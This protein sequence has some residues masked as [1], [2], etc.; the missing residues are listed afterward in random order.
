[1]N[2]DRLP[3]VTTLL[4][5]AL[6]AAACNS[7]AQDPQASPAVVATDA[8]AISAPVGAATAA[9]PAATSAPAAP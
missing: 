2:I 7:A 8:P 6:F 9:A 1:M 5:V 4:L 3:F